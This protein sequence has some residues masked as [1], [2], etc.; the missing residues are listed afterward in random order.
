MLMLEKYTEDDYPL[1]AQ[2]V[3]NEQA[4]NMNLGR[5]FTEEEANLFFQMVLNCNAA[6]PDL[7]FYKV[8]FG[9]EYIGMGALNQNDAYNAVE[10]EYMLLPQ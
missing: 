1:Y 6:S 2:L 7:G 9:K 3:F 10:I 4:M 5:V 8:F